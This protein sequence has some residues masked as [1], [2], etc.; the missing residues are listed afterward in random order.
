MVCTEL[1]DWVQV[2]ELVSRLEHK[3][4]VSK[5]QG[6]TRRLRAYVGLLRQAGQ[7]PDRKKLDGAWHRIPKRFRRQACL[8]AVYVEERL[9]FPATGDCEPLLRQ[10]LKKHWRPN[11][12]RLYGEVEGH[13]ADKQLAFAERQLARHANEPVLL[14]TLGR[15]C[16]RNSLWGRGRNYLQQSLALA[17]T[18][19]AYREL[20]ALMEQQGEPYA[21]ALYYQQGLECATDRQRQNGVR[22]P[23]NKASKDARDKRTP[24]PAAQT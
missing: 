24:R 3:G 18:P 11:L 9:R 10:H 20:A 17:P 6:Q 1:Q 14:L 19:T 4:L 21:A 8:L 2:L 12:V 13:E 7:S 23:D 16:R 5:K 15:L 22:P